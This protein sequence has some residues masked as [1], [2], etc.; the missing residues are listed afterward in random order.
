VA[1]TDHADGADDIFSIRAHPDHFSHCPAFR[2]RDF[3]VQGPV[4]SAFAAVDRRV[5]AVFGPVRYSRERV[6]PI[7]IVWEVR[8]CYG[9]G[10]VRAARALR[11]VSGSRGSR[12]GRRSAHSGPAPN[13]DCPNRNMERGRELLLREL[14]RVVDDSD[15]WHATGASPFRIRHRP[16][17]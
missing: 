15:L 9:L 5:P 2:E 13:L 1:R 16:S 8:R 6:R 14:Q 3:D 4:N 10:F 11:T 17:I 7:A 12:A